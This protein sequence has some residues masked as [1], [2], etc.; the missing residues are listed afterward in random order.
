[1]SHLTEYRLVTLLYVHIDVRCL[2]CGRAWW[3]GEEECHRNECLAFLFNGYRDTFPEH[4]Q[5]QEESMKLEDDIEDDTLRLKKKFEKAIANEDPRA[6]VLAMLQ[7]A[8]DTARKEKAT[9]DE[10]SK[11]CGSA[12]GI[13]TS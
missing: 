3:K 6:A 12:W 4:E 10:F 9:A 5:E 2:F 1:M 13:E 11:L 8:A 7:V